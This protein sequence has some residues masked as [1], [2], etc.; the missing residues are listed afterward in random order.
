M[1]LLKVT[2]S[3][4]YRS[5]SPK[6]LS[7]TKVMTLWKYQRQTKVMWILSRTP[8]FRSTHK[9]FLKS[10]NCKKKTSKIVAWWKC[11]ELQIYQNNL[12]ITLKL[13]SINWVDL[14]KPK[15]T[16]SF[17]IRTNMKTIWSF[18]ITPVPR[19]CGISTTTS[20]QNLWRNNWTAHSM[21]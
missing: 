6:L 13:A 11:K 1:S 18:I 2:S 3:R 8:S 4:K 7:L 9:W 16:K 12:C 21:K 14:A 15:T 20:L 17:L 10:P 5:S 19:K